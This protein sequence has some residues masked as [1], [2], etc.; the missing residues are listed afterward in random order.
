MTFV[1]MKILLSLNRGKNVLDQK[2]EL[3]RALE[4]REL[5]KKNKAREAEKLVR[6]SS[7]ERKL[8]ERALRVIR[9]EHEEQTE[10]NTPEFFKI[11]AKICEKRQE[12]A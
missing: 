8:E 7:L 11:H 4:Q 10:K 1:N 5:S 12:V 3:A 6:K 2:T 9:H